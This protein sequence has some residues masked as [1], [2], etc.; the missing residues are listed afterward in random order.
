MADAPYTLTRDDL[1]ALRE[2]DA[3]SFHYVKSPTEGELGCYVRLTKRHDDSNSA[4]WSR[5]DDAERIIEAQV[6]LTAYDRDHTAS[7]AQREVQRGYASSLSAKFDPHWKTAVAN[8]KV[9]D[10]LRLHFIAGN[11]TE[12]LNK[13]GLVHDEFDLRIQRCKD[14]QRPVELTFRIDDSICPVGS[15]ARMVGR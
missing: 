4:V 11:N 1:K 9:G 12:T 2:A 7:D 6:I 5:E 8:M 10:A 15:S 13:L 14:G 3:V